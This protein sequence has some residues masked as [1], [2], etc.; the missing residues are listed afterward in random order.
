MARQHKNNKVIYSTNPDFEMWDEEKEENDTLPP[1]QQKLVILL[2][3]KQR[4][5]K[6]VT[7]IKEFVGST[8]DLKEL[9]KVIKTKCGVG[10]SV[11]EGEI[12]IQ[13]DF[14]EKIK[15]ILEKMQYNCKISG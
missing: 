7:L 14:R 15:F 5:G 2:D 13:G 6:K 12:I 1:Q 9:G 4:K 11:K 3:K 8:T 10:G